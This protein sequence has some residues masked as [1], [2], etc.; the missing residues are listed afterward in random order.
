MQSESVCSRQQRDQHLYTVTNSNVNSCCVS[1]QLMNRRPI[2]ECRRESLWI[3]SLIRSRIR[4]ATSTDLDE[5]SIISPS[6]MSLQN[7]LLY[8]VHNQ[9]ILRVCENMSTALRN[10]ILIGVSACLR[11][12]P[13]KGRPANDLLL[14][15][16]HHRGS[17]TEC[18]TQRHRFQRHHLV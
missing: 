15:K 16:R 13:H 1:V 12:E 6:L 3:R 2:F 5:A 8:K 18:F 17:H 4:N 11:G 10:V 9:P 14:G 7:C